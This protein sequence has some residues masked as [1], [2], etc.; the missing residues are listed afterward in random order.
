MDLELTKEQAMFR[1]MAKEFAQREIL[2]TTRERDREA[3]FF[4]EIVK[5]TG[6]QGLSGVMVPK[7]YGGLG[8][9]W[10]TVGL[11]AEQICYFDFAVGIT[12][13]GQTSLQA[14]P[15]LSAGDEAQKK[16]YLPPLA[17]GEIVGCFAAV[18]PNAGSD[19]TAIETTAVLDGDSWVLNGNKTWITN[20]TVA[21]FALVLAQTDRSKGTKGI[22]T[23][24]VDRGTP[25]FS[26]TKIEHKLG[27]RSNDIGQLFFRDCRIPRTNQ[28][29]PVGRGMGIALGSIEHTR[30]GIAWAAVGL[31]Q[32][33]IDASVKY[34]QERIQFGKSIA[35][36]QLVQER[37]AEMVVDCEASRWL[38]Y[39]VAYLK[40]KGLS[41]SRETAIAKLHNVE[42]AAK[43]AKAAVELHGA[44]GF[45][46]DFP[47]ERH[48]RDVIAPL[49][50]GG[51][52]HVQKLIIGRL[53][54]GIDAIAR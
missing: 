34:C 37:I 6:Q 8:L 21:D 54:L 1:D 23:F 7:E 43:A 30:F 2:P 38:A 50:F 44:Y 45:S 53:T 20:A 15:I 27:V 18:E 12:L 22:T 4:P 40:D 36:F 3:K 42:A 29:G 14:M 17:R 35:S 11:I 41:Y 26:H 49:I 5:K 13:F 46:D 32:A 10:L 28:L 31:M 9:D 25:G 33:C 51:T 39:R 47:V 24:L 48:Y 16:K 19:A 52:S